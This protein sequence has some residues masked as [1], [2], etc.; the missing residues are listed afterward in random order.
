N[1]PI[2]HTHPP[3]YPTRRSS[4]LAPQ[5]FPESSTSIGRSIFPRKRE[6][7]LTSVLTQAISLVNSRRKS[8]STAANC[9][10]MHS[11]RVTN[12]GLIRSEEHTS[13]LQSL[14]Y[15]VCRLL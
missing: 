2:Y 6:T 4:D 8:A 14:A 10:A 9:G 7:C 13:E 15:L 12:A 3:P 1:H 11:V 5:A